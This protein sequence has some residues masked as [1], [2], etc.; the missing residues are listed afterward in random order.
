MDEILYWILYN[1]AKT[2]K[3]LAIKDYEEIEKWTASSSSLEEVRLPYTIDPSRGEVRLKTRVFLRPLNATPYFIIQGDIDAILLINNDYYYGIDRWTRIIPIRGY[4]GW[5]DVELYLPSRRV[6]GERF[7]PIVLE[8]VY[9]VYI[10]EEIN[11]YADKILWLLELVRTLDDE[12]AV[13]A[14]LHVL[15]SSLDMVEASIPAPKQ[16]LYARSMRFPSY[17]SMLYDELLRLARDKPSRLIE[18]GYGAL[19]YNKLKEEIRR[20]ERLLEEKLRELREKY[21]KRGIIHAVAHSHIDVAWLW[22]PRDTLYKVAR[23]LSKI[24]RQLEH[25]DFPVYVFS[26]ALFMDWLSR[27]YPGLYRRF[28]EKIR[29][30][31]IIPVGGMWVESDTIIIPSESLVRQFLYGQRFYEEKLGSRTPYGWLPDSFG[32]SPN[33]PQILSEAGIKLFVLHKTEWNKYNKIPYHSFRWRGIDGTEVYAHVLIGTYAQECD[34]KSLLNTWKKYHEKQVVPRTIYAYGYGDGGGGPTDE[35]Y[36]KLEFYGKNAPILPKTIHGGL[37]EFME[38]M[39]KNRSRLPVW[40]GELY[41]ELHRGTYTTNTCIKKMVWLTDYY[42]RLLEQIATWNYVLGGE[43]PAEQLENMWREL[44]LSEFHDILPGTATNEVFSEVCSTLSAKIVEAS[45]TAKKMLRRIIGNYKGVTVYNPV[46]WTR[47]EIIELNEPIKQIENP[48][49]ISHRGRLILEVMV[50]G[51]GYTVIPFSRIGSLS[52]PGVRTWRCNDGVCIENEYLVVRIDSRGRIT[53]IYDKEVG[54]E[55]LEKPSHIVTLHEDIPHAWDAW[56]IDEYSIKRYHELDAGN[57]EILEEGPLRAIVMIR[58][59]NGSSSLVVYVKM[60]RG[61]RRIDF[62]VN[63]SIRERRKLLKAWFYPMINTDYAWFDTPYGVIKRPVH[64]NT[65]WDRARFEVPMLSWMALEEGGYG[66]A[67]ISPVKH[68]VSVEYNSIGLSL[69][70]TPIYPDPLSDSGTVSFSYTII[71]YPGSWLDAGIHV[72]A[73]KMANPLLVYVSDI[74]REPSDIISNS[75]IEVSPGNVVLKSIKKAEDRDTIIMRFFETGNRRGILRIKTM[76]PVEGAWRTN[77]L[78]DRI[79][80]IKAN[81]GL[82]EYGYRPYEIIT[83]E[84]STPRKTG[85]E[86]DDNRG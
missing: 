51:N 38:D 14:I 1:K 75:F 44:L 25:Y 31:R 36:R 69:L 62:E 4:S 20:A 63:A 74:G 17:F 77:I 56:D 35:M 39:E 49:Q 19:D 54:R 12:E 76:F 80:K 27:R 53:S 65:S 43:Y 58:Y 16:F 42:V 48:V 46:Q 26:S 32:Y 18:A 29:D 24:L 2:L 8:K 33:L 55:V 60:Y 11:G 52:E 7:Q 30:K 41:V 10:D 15:S 79:T 6:F 57:V 67:L 50:P 81:K 73:E 34:A 66:F 47:R 5:I 23:T 82:V 68:G 61:S 59:R 84:V 21:P 13:D 3:V 86:V 9:M 45:Q 85:E 37:D 40:Y 83:I 22:S 78:E 71:P 70:K 64:R 72:E 28:V